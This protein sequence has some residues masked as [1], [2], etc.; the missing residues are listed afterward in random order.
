[1]KQMWSKCINL[2]VG[3]VLV[4][5]HY[6]LTRWETPPSSES[7]V[8][9][10]WVALTLHWQASPA[11]RISC[12]A[13]TQREGLVSGGPR[14]GDPGPDT[15]TTDVSE[16]WHCLMGKR[17][18]EYSFSHSDSPTFLPWAVKLRFASGEHLIISLGEL[19]PDGPGYMPDS[20]LVTDSR[21]VAHALRPQAALGTAWGDDDKQ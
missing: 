3:D 17:L 4:G 6:E 8:D 13:D 10:V 14:E 7:P 5:I 2:P 1:V 18:E 20:L 16:R 15:E 21:E 12:S 9:E 19:L 11:T